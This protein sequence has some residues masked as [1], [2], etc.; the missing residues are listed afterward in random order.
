MFRIGGKRGGWGG[1]A[2]FRVTGVT[3]QLDGDVW[4]FAGRVTR[5]SEETKPWEFT[6]GI[7]LAGETGKGDLIPVAHLDTD[8]G[9]V[10]PGATAGTVVVP[11]NVS[12]VNFSGE[13]RAANEELRAIFRNTRMRVE[14]R[15]RFR[16]EQ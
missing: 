12:R 14:V 16:G 15:P 10:R 1:P 7:W 8:R 9:E 4:R 11:E 13:T 2:K 6:V 3:A 5:Q